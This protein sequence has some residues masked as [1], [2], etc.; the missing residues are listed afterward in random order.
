MSF[1]LPENA[2]QYRSVFLL[3]VTPELA[4]RWLGR[5]Y[6]NRKVDPATV[7]RYFR[8]IIYGR[9]RRTH[10]GIAFDRD[11]VLLDGQHRLQ[12]VC[13][14]NRTVPMLIFTN[15]SLTN[16]EVIDGGK[17]RTNL[18]V[19]QIEL[20]DT[21]INSK[22][23]STLRAMRAGRLCVRP[24]WSSKE[25]NDEYRYHHDAIHFAVNQLQNAWSG[26]INHAVVRGVVAR[27]YYNIEVPQLQLFCGHLKSRND[28]P[29]V[30]ADLCDWLVRLTD[31][32]ENT[33]R[34][35]YKQTEYT[36]HAFLEG[37]DEVNIPFGTGELFPLK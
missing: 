23:L 20:Q 6:L 28:Q 31:N 19:I 9:W 36:L 11:G 25:L 24:N 18:D 29:N 34:E 3:D 33:R 8:Q 10:Q 35:I 27:A 14:A 12:A 22:H 1:Q 16:H 26:R 2:E 4:K 32:R 7:D 17:S 37:R 21:R 15:Q 13:K 5:N 30:V